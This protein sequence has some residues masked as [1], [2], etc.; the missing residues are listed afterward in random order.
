MVAVIQPN[1]NY[2]A[3]SRNRRFQVHFFALQNVGGTAMD[4]MGGRRKKIKCQI[5]AFEKIRSRKSVAEKLRR[6]VGYTDVI[7]K[8]ADTVSRTGLTR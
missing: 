5:E 8:G 4:R 7:E 6:E 2:L 1:A 3:R